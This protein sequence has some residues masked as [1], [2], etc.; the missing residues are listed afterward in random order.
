MYRGRYWSDR[1]FDLVDVLV[2][3]AR[4]EGVS[5][6]QAAIAWTLT[7]DGVTSPIVGASRP[8]QLEETTKAAGV[9]LSEAAVKRLDEA[10][11]MF[12]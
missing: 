3:V 9:K 4:D 11:A 10:S 1:M 5:P 8:E 12:A 2:S 7:R 6:A